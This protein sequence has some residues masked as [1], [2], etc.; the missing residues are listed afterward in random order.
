MRKPVSRRHWKKR[1]LKGLWLPT[2]VLRAYKLSPPDG[3]IEQPHPEERGFWRIVRADNETS[4]EGL[5]GER[6]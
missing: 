6:S 2:V 1:W 3:Y 4:V 5:T